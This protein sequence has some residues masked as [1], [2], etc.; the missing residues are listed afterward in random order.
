MGR[1]NLDQI[2]E[3]AKQIQE[4]AER[5]EKGGDGKYNWYDMQ[6]GQNVFRLLGPHP[7]DS[8]GKLAFP[9]LTHFALPVNDKKDQYQVCL[10]TWPD[11]TAQIKC[12]ICET[13]NELYR[14]GYSTLRQLAQTKYKANIIARSDEAK[15]VQIVTI[16]QATYA[17]LVMQINARSPKP[18]YDRL[19]GDITDPMTGCDVVVTK[20]G[21]GKE[22]KYQ[23]SLLPPSKLS[24]NPEQA[25]AWLDGVI[26]IDAIWKKPDDAQIM[27]LKSLRDPILLWYHANATK[28]EKR[29][30][31]QGQS[32][33]STLT[34]NLGTSPFTES[35]GTSTA[36]VSP[37]LPTPAKESKPVCYGKAGIELGDH[38]EA[39]KERCVTCAYETGCSDIVKTVL[40]GAAA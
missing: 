10:G 37:T 12:P 20:I 23:T 7:N 14:E 5:R 24:E 31:K 11:I 9:V 30:K 38:W 8:A 18:P 3:A 34:P 32:T 26:D 27:K 28:D 36:P 17:Y 39:A 33:P 25:K 40:N 2:D 19:F 35:P 1:L 16:G 29:A 4:Q 21:S 15:G 6:T 22:T 13:L